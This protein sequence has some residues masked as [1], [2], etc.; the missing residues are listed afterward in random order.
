MAYNQTEGGER[1][2]KLTL[3]GR[4]WT[5][6]VL[7]LM[8]P[9]GGLETVSTD[10]QLLRVL[11]A[12]GDLPYTKIG[13]IRKFNL[14]SKDSQRIFGLIESQGMAKLVRR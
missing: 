2:Y 7:D 8:G 14:S 4:E 10:P 1:V 6:S 9:E 5:D 3:K 11:E 12:I 13:L